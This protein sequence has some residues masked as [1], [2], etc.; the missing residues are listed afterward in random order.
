MQQTAERSNGGNNEQGIVLAVDMGSKTSFS[1]SDWPTL[2]WYAARSPAGRVQA[3]LCDPSL[4]KPD[5]NPEAMI[6]Q[7]FNVKEGEEI[8][9]VIA[10]E[11]G[12]FQI[13]DKLYKAQLSPAH[14]IM[15]PPEKNNNKGGID[16]FFMTPDFPY[17]GGA[18]LSSPI[19][20]ISRFV[21]QF[22][23]A[24]K[25]SYDASCRKREERRAVTPV[26]IMAEA[27]G[28]VLHA[29]IWVWAISLIPDTDNNS[30][31]VE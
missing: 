5:M 8:K 6:C 24:V 26:Y 20:V 29:E 7:D 19:Q 17:N 16:P 30:T 14:D 9:V 25:N 27:T 1:I 21:N 13:G 28:P 22:K 2:Y 18:G 23:T 31:V 10:K 3:I 4:A 12:R 15:L 11:N